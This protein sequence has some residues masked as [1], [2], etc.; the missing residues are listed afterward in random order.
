MT[1]G[2][3]ATGWRVYRARRSEFLD[4]RRIRRRTTVCGIV[5]TVVGALAV[6]AQLLWGWSGASEA[7]GLVVAVAFAATTG[8]FTAVF[9]RTSRQVQ[10]QPSSTWPEGW[11]RAERI[12]AQFSA[13]PPE[14]DPEDR[15]AVLQR[16][17]RA[18]E[19]AVVTIDRVR[20]IPA[21]WFVGWIGAL[22]IGSA[23]TDVLVPLVLP[24]VFGL[25]QGS[26]TIAAVTGLGRAELAR[27]RAAATPPLDP[28]PPLRHRNA[29]PHGSKVPLPGE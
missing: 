9:V 21:G 11:R 1:D 18:V 10:A 19:P 2:V 12:G 15:D 27:R 28:A 6:V 24:L 22:A 4:P 5:A 7:A 23:S 26:T 17:E 13:R 25:L 3:F 20:W 16:A 29:E 8:C 14:L